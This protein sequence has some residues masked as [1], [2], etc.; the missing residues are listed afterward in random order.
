[1]RSFLILPLTECALIGICAGLIGALA[2]LRSRIFFAESI[3]HATFPGAVLGVVIG[4]TFLSGHTAL[5]LCLFI[6]AFLMCLPMSW[7]MGRLT[8]IPGI[9]E[10]SAAGLVLTFSFA[11]GYFLATWFSPLP[12]QVASFLTGSILTITASDVW[13]CAALL[14]ITLIIFAGWGRR[15]LFLCFDEQG[16]SALHGRSARTEY[17]LLTLITLCVVVLIPAVGTVLSIALLA[18]PAAGLK[19]LISRTS[20][21]LIASPICGMLIAFS[22]FAASLTFTISTGGCIAVAAGIFYVGCRALHA[23]L[24]HTGRLRAHETDQ[25]KQSISRA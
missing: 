10:Q 6:G 19:P 21:Y 2:V 18:A 13:A 25:G 3:T 24:S 23:V 1:M 11:L 9:S 22:G 16:F 5:S 14:L 17:T 8:R 20:T 15:L 7:L 12:L 4:S